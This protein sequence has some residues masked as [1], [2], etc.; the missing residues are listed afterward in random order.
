MSQLNNQ[1]SKTTLE[2]SIIQSLLN[3]EESHRVSPSKN[4]NIGAWL[5]VKHNL[6]HIYSK[7]IKSP[8]NQKSKS[9]VFKKPRPLPVIQLRKMQSKTSAQ[10]HFDISPFNRSIEEPNDYSLTNFVFNNTQ[11]KTTATDFHFISTL[12]VSASA[13]PGCL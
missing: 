2:L 6:T 13:L 9:I 12:S 8:T 3:N 11:Q 4:Y 5:E 10:I 7:N 1:S